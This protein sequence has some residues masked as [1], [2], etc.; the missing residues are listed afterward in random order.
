[1]SLLQVNPEKMTA[2][3]LKNELKSRKLPCSGLVTILKE[4]LTLSILSTGDSSPAYRGVSLSSDSIKHLRASVSAFDLGRTAYS[5][6][7][8]QD[9]AQTPDAG[10]H[11]HLAIAPAPAADA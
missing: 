3:D 6:P 4:R 10:M 7:E 1:M 9:A 11:Q 8:I 5:I 2:A